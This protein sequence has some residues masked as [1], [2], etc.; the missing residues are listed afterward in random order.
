MYVIHKVLYLHDGVNVAQYC[1]GVFTDLQCTAKLVQ[2]TDWGGGMHLPVA[3]GNP[4]SALSSSLL[5]FCTVHLWRQQCGSPCSGG[6]RSY[7]TCVAVCCRCT[8]H[9]ESTHASLVGVW[10]LSP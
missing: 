5:E 10:S 7:V 1:F 3:R 2:H 6:I 9:Q 8:F 4:S